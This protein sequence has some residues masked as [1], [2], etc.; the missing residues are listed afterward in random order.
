MFDIKVSP[1]MGRGLYANRVI[2][3]G[4]TIMQCEILVLDD[5][6]TILV[7]RT[8]LRFYTFAFNDEQDCIVLGLGEIFNHDDNANVSY[9]L[10]D[11]EGRKVMV[12][13]ALANIMPGVQ[14]FINYK[15][16]T[17]VNVDGYIKNKSMVG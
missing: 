3:Q 10:V 5:F 1:E 11:F 12:F 4:E 13:K 9:E 7:N 6:D 17:I 15:A 2:A 8:E 16:D 14:L